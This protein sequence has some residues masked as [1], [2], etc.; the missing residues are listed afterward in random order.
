MASRKKWKLWFYNRRTIKDK[1]RFKE[2]G[3]LN[4][5]T[6]GAVFG[7]SVK[8]KGERILEKETRTQA[9]S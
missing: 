1:I 2:K 5:D 9:I 6:M 4:T 7:G 3:I 8:P